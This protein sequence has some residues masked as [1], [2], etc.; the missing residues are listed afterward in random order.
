MKRE[1]STEENSAD[2][3]KRSSGSAK[4]VILIVVLVLLV[5]VFGVAAFIVARDTI[6]SKTEDQANRSIIDAVESLRDR[7]MEELGDNENDGV[8]GG[9]GE[10]FEEEL[11]PGQR[12]DGKGLY[13]KSGV[14]KWL[15]PSYEENNDLAGWLIIEGT[16]VDYP[17]M[18]TPYWV[19]KYLRKA[20]D[21][22]YALSGTLFIGGSWTPDSDYTVIYGHHMKDGTMF[23]D[24]VDYEQLEYARTH[25]KIHFETL[26][27]MYDYEVLFAINT[28]VNA[29]AN[30]NTFDYYTFSSLPDEES[31]NAFIARA[32]AASLYDTGVDVK[33]GD[34]IIV[35][36]TC[37]YH[38][39][40]ERFVVIGRYRD[41]KKPLN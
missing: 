23:S 16:Y 10:R 37:N 36:S 41:E 27:K 31:F 24:L 17:V 22:S 15:E 34:K 35:L 26:T 25:S 11:L 28:Q 29:S 12:A 38:R 8:N 19:E 18:Y 7:A 9:I 5:G 39:D 30:E 4:R 1:V 14:F 40:D 20:F 21:Q 6:R 32:R 3:E 2:T 13:G 33:F